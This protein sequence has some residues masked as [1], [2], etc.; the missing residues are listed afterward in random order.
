[1]GSNKMGEWIAIAQWAECQRLARPGVMFEIQ[2]A[3]GQ[4]LLTPCVVPPP[5]VPFDWRSPPLRFRVVA[6]PAAE[7]TSPIPA[8]RGR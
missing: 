1:M 3:D 6:E 7:H 8:P 5:P 4:S 2:N